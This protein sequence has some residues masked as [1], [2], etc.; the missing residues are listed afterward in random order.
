MRISRAFHVMTSVAVLSIGAPMLAGAQ[1]S[2]IAD[3]LDRA[4]AALNDLKFEQADSLAL[5]VLGTFE[6]QLTRNQRIDALSIAAAALFPDPLAGG[7]QRP[8]SALR[9]MRRIVR[10][11]QGARFRQDLAWRGLDSL[12]AIALRS[13]LALGMRATSELV[14]T[15]A[16]GEAEVEF[17]TTRPASLRMR[18]IAA[19][20]GAPV[21]ID[22][23]DSGAPATLRVRAF[24]GDQPA[25]ASGEY[26]IDVTA[27]DAANADSVVARFQATV[28]APPLQRVLVRLAIDSTRLLSELDPPAHTRGIVTG[29]LLAA[30][31]AAA[32]TISG[33]APLKA[34]S[35]SGLGY[36]VGAGLAVGAIVAGFL[37]NGHALPANVASNAQLRT[38]FDESVRQAKAE[39]ARRLA[40]Y[41][42]T[43]TLRGETH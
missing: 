7:T 43:I 4:R 21:A 38:E 20:G 30:G 31:A 2:P 42:V 35:T 6:G 41:R 3:L 17:F 22:S 1:T 33:P 13:T 23:A 16:R 29:L 15:G 25:L 34:G 10:E 19:T 5:A 12:Y 40:A 37:D 32:A 8:D 18:M 14:L 11:A 26:L 39:N 9:L 24:R 27:H 28:A 36:V